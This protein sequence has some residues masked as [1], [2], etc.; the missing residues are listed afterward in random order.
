VKSYEEFLAKRLRGRA[1]VAS[2][3]DMGYF[4]AYDL[5]DLEENRDK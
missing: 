5:N 3:R 2:L 4:E 1:R